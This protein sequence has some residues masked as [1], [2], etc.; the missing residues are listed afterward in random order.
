MNTFGKIY[1]LTSFGESHGKAIGGVIDGIPANLEIDLAEI[2]NELNRRRPG[3]NELT[4]P[5]QEK[6]RIEILS[7]LEDGKTLGSPIGFLVRNENIRP[8][9]YDKISRD[10]RPGHADF[11][12]QEKYGILA[13]SGGGRASARETI[14][15]VVAG[16]FAKQVLRKNTE[17]KISAKIS[18]IH[19][20]Q[21]PAKFEEI[22]LQAKNEGDS[23]GGI[24]ECRVEKMPIGLGEPVFD[25]LE[26]DFAKAMLSIPATK[27]FEIGAGFSAT[28]M[29]GGEHND[30]MKIAENGEIEF[31]TNK[32]GGVLGGISNGND[33]IFRVA[34]KPTSTIQKPQQTVSISRENSVLKNVGG[35]HDPCVLPRALPIVEAM[36]A[37]VL[38]DHFLRNKTLQ[39]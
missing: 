14:S 4:T 30:E 26:A 22:I 24:I 39:I 29:K 1:R 7:G 10:F 12:Y 9:D 5:R 25:R 20:E 37:H 2:Q 13:K 3:Q 17:L 8:Q 21:N 32:A 38:L 28:K 31:L 11:T 33:L 36:T 34:F 35:R 15:R 16:A 18:E 27:G 19:G 23:V 6:D